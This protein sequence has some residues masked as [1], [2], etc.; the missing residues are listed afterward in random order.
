MS[1]WTLD[2]HALRTDPPYWTTAWFSL[3]VADM[4]MLDTHRG[5]EEGR[6]DVVKC[7]SA[8]RDAPAW[9]CE[10]RGKL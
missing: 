10:W 9:Q 6:D 8:P 2:G 1:W 5:S 3:E 4:K 7:G